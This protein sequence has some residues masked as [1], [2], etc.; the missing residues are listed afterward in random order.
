MA[1]KRL[2]HSNSE[3]VAGFIQGQVFAGGVDGGE[4]VVNR[5]C[6]EPGV[7]VA[8]FVLHGLTSLSLS[9]SLSLYA[10]VTGGN[11]SLVLTILVNIEIAAKRV[12]GIVS[13]RAVLEV[14]MQKPHVSC[15]PHSILAVGKYNLRVPVCQRQSLLTL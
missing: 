14:I 13:L 8:G 11:D 2:G 4:R 10:C 12:L 3:C 5:E 6:Y 9:L 1:E 15:R 7:I